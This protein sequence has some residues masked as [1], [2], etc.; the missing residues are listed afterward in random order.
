MI[1]VIFNP[2][3]NQFFLKQNYICLCVFKFN[4]RYILKKQVL[5]E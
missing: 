3:I 5:I 4:V 1:A 2:N